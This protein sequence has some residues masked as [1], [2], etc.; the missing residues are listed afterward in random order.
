MNVW[1]YSGSVL[2]F[3]TCSLENPKDTLVLKPNVFQQFDGQ[4][5]MQTGEMSNLKDQNK[6]KDE[7]DFFTL[8]V[9]FLCL[10]FVQNLIITG[11]EDGF[12][13]QHFFPFV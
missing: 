10:C 13:S 4:D 5:L 9:T 8:E 3:S 11:G 7:E 12:V 1:K 2:T 6:S